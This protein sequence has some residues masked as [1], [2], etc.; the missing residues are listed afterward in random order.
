MGT[1]DKL[2]AAGF[3]QQEM[4][5]YAA[6]Q[7]QTLSAAGFSPQ[8]ISDYLGG[9]VGPAQPQPDMREANASFAQNISN[10]LLDA[11]NLVN[12]GTGKDAL[13][14]VADMGSV[15]GPVEAAMNFA[16]N[17]KRASCPSKAA[18]STVA[19][20]STSSPVWRDSC[21]VVHRQRQS[22]AVDR[23]WTHRR[24]PA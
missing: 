13:Q 4:A 12:V 3:S 9:T 14:T 18:R 19:R 20:R 5:D 10:H 23:G 2:A 15:Y 21:F 8:E 16:A 7:H 17:V 1:L 6:Q 24:R 22:R 11:H